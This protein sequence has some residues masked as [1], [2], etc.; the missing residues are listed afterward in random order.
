MARV[1][2]VLA[3]QRADFKL[4]SSRFLFSSVLCAFTP[5]FVGQSVGPSVGLTVG[6]L[7]FSTFFGV[8]QLFE[9]TAQVT[10]SITASTHPHGLVFRCVTSSLLYSI[11]RYNLFC[12]NFSLSIFPLKTSWSWEGKKKK[13][14]RFFISLIIYPSFLGPGPSDSCL[15]LN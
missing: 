9:L 7:L 10:F 1:H 5:R 3:S 4:S 6:R 2:K 13:M 12:I 8:F 15:T 14:S 11:L